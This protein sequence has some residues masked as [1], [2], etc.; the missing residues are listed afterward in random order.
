MTYILTKHSANDYVFDNEKTYDQIK[1]AKPKG[2]WFS[3]DTCEH[4]WEKFCR[5]EHF[6]LES[7]KF[8]KTFKFTDSA[9]VLIITNLQEFDS[10]CNSYVVRDDA[11]LGF[12]STY[13]IDWEAV[14]EK[15]D[16]I[17]IPD[18]YWERR[19]DESSGWYYG[20]DCAS[21]CI[22]NLSAI[23]EI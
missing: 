6:W 12:L 8:K 18:Y 16:G 23:E 17:Y 7:L 14:A 3:N 13:N 4:N 9:N 10:F 15:Y 22:W 21:G 19:L 11:H 5:A 1:S 20:W 2:F